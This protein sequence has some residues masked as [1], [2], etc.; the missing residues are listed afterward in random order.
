MISRRL[1]PFVLAAVQLTVVPLVLTPSASAQPRGGG[2]GILRRKLPRAGGPKR[3]PGQ[4][5]KQID[6]INGL[7]PRERKRLIDRLPPERRKEAERRLQRFNDMSPDEQDRLLRDYSEFQNE[8]PERQRA[9]RRLWTQFNDFPER[10]KPT[11]RDEVQTLRKMAPEERAER[12]AT[13]EFRDKYN[14][15]ERR[16]LADMADTFEPE[17]PAETNERAPGRPE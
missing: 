12:M 9:V 1:I 8:S 15:S 11:V 7:P 3:N 16:F 10:R 6:R 17:R 14:P 4:M 2:V 13:R 5:K